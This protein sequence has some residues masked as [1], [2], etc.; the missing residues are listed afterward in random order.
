M[1][2]Q[3]FH[4]LKKGHPGGGANLKGMNQEFGFQ[5]IELDISIRQPSS[6]I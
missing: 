2:E 6:D 1:D 4:L 3:W 5:H